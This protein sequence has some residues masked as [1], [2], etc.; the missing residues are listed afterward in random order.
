RAIPLYEA[1]LAQCEQALGD[2]HPTT[3]A[4]R[5]NLASAY[6][7]AGDLERAIS[8]YEVTVARCEQTLGDAHPDTLTSRN[9]LTCAR[10]AVQAVQHGST[11]IESTGKDL[12]P[13]T[14]KN[15]A[16]TPSGH[17]H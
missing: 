15:A 8:L 14:V 10:R 5:N 11:Q 6:Q 7:Q 1:A 3:L 4:C 17:S 9:N 2:S 12:Q 13:L 16:P